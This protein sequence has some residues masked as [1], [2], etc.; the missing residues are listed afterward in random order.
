[1]TAMNTEDGIADFQR[2]AELLKLARSG[3][4]VAMK[5]LVDDLGPLLWRVARYQGLSI[6]AAADV[7]QTA[8]M[9]LVK[10]WESI[11]EPQ[12]VTA[13]L[14]TTVRRDA[15]RIRTAARRESTIDPV[16]FPDPPSPLTDS[17][18][19]QL[20]RKQE[21]RAVRRVLARTG[22]PCREL[23]A[24]ISAAERPDYDVIAQSLGMKKGSI[25]PTRG[26]CL[27]RLRRDLQKEPD[28]GHGEER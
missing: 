18:D 28:W 6:D 3:D 13:W 26:R 1:M 9:K 4:R 20:I 8:W 12:A 7:V 27:A 14:T 25:G 24:Y 21:H 11:E 15:Q 23:L 10:H 5:S 19:E 17:V 2:R 22:S 16:E